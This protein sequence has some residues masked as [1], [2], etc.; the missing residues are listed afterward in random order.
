MKT[1]RSRLSPAEEAT[2]EAA[3]REMP[4]ARE[5][6]RRPTTVEREELVEAEGGRLEPPEPPRVRAGEEGVEGSCSRSHSKEERGEPGAE[7]G[8]EG[9]ERD[10][11]ETERGSS[12][13][14]EEGVR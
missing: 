1:M 10:P 3:L 7:L 5:W 14:R 2:V 4:S 6:A 12:S 11:W 9:R 13:A 8:S